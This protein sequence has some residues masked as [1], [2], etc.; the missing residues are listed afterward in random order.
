M[1]DIGN[2]HEQAPALGAANFG[3][4][5]VH[6]IVKIAGIFAVNGDQRH[7]AQIHPA[8]AV[9]GQDL[10][11]QCFCCGQAVRREHMRHAVFAHGNF[12]FH[13]RVIDLAQYLNHF[14][15]GLAI[16]GGCFGQ[17]NNNDL[18]RFTFPRPLRQQ[19]ILAKAFVL[20]GQ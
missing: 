11:G 6:G 12:N 4:F 9:F 16:Q 5:A 17:G 10:V 19:H 8:F 2:R 1:A 7:I 15:N 20:R 13:A 3:A 14:A 18:A